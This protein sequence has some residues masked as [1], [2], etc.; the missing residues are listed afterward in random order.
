MYHISS[1]LEYVFALTSAR[2]QSVQIR[3]NVTHPT[4]LPDNARYFLHA[5]GKSGFGLLYHDSGDAELIALFSLVSG[6][7]PD[8]VRLSVVNGANLLD[9]FDGFL[10][11][12]YESFGFSEYARESNWTP[13]LPDVVYM[14]L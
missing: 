11:K 4:E 14:S 8:M 5:D 7:G 6:R 3:E 10:P 9:C 12:Y 2:D 13:G 1:K